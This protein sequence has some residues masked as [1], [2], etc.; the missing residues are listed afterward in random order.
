MSKLHTPIRSVLSLAALLACILMVTSCSPPAK[1]HEEISTPTPTATFT[2]VATCK[3]EIITTP[4]NTP[5]RL[6]AT[7]EAIIPLDLHSPLAGFDIPAL[8]EIV[9]TPFEQPNPGMDDGHHGVDFSFYTYQNF[10]TIEGVPINSVL[11][12]RVASVVEDRLPYGN[13]LMIET[14]LDSLP[15]DW[16]ATLDLPDPVQPLPGNPRLNCPPKADLPPW[17]S[18]SRSLYLLYAHLLEP[19]PFSIDD[20]IA[21]GDPIGFV[22]NSG[23]S[24]NPHLHLEARVGPSNATFTD[25]A[26]YSNDVTDTEMSN[27]CSWRIGGVFQMIDPL[28]LFLAQP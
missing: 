18:S 9:S 24:G 19:A 12:G 4:R 11:S 20:P 26:H 2:I 28:S 16:V 7:R 17:D 14:P 13:M 3:S 25:M 10:K 5:T 6:E 15:E 8:L 1:T 22:G 21:S 23:A 27:Y